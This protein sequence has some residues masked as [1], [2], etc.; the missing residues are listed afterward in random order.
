MKSQQRHDLK[1]NA[2][3]RIATRIAPFFQQHGQ[4]IVLG[5]CGAIVVLAIVIIWVRSSSSKSNNAWQKMVASAVSPSDAESFLTIAGEN[6]YRGSQVSVWARLL[7]AERHYQNGISHYF[8]DRPTG[9]GEMELA[10]KAF[11][12]V[13]DS[14]EVNAVM[15]ERALFG[16]ARCAE[17]TSKENTQDAITAYQRLLSEFPKSIY[18]E[19]SQKR[20]EILK[21]IE[22]QNFYAWFSQQTTPKPEGLQR[23]SDGANTGS[24][25]NDQFFP[26]DSTTEKSDPFGDLPKFQPTE[27]GKSQSADEKKQPTSEPVSAPKPPVEATRPQPK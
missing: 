15:Q 23:P 2:L 5:M 19:D 14:D 7:S 11:Q 6:A 22:T 9:V 21:T 17:T 24:S 1:T 13:L 20:I 4:R 3:E 10:R 16:L 25:E 18:K 27:F 8:T 12:I 26:L